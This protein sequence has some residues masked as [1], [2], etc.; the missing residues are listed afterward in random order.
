VP[1]Y[2]LRDVIRR[3]LSSTLAKVLSLPSYDPRTFPVNQCRLIL[4]GLT[5]KGVSQEG[6]SGHK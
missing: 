6:G 1:C 3:R 2:A 5:S 4:T